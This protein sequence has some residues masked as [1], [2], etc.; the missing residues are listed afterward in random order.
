MYV[1][2]HEWD[3]VVEYHTSIFLPFWTAIEDQM[4]KWTKDNEPLY[5][6]LP[7]FPE[8]KHIILVTH[9]ESTFYANDRRK[10]WWI[11]INEKAQ[12]VRKGEGS[13][14]MV[15]DFCSPDLGWLKSKDK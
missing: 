14:I 15:S 5:P 9:D 1:D 6:R 3:D 2:G 10:T 4:I 13:S 11:H 8:Q 7:N 12:P